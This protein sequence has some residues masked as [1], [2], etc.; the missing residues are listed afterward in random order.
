MENLRLRNE[1]DAMTTETM[2]A[3]EMPPPPPMPARAK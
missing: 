3:I 1:I 2:N